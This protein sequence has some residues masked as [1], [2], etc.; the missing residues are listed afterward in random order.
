[1]AEQLI[2]TCPVCNGSKRMPAV[3]SPH[4]AICYGY[5]EATNTFPCDNCGG[6]KQSLEPTGIVPLRSNGTPCTHEYEG[7]KIS[8]CYWGYKCKHCPDYFTIDSGD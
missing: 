6:Q 2:G 7:K 5:D 3:D 1:M 4:K 8:N